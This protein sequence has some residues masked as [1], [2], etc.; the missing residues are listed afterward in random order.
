MI[1]NPKEYCPQDV[2]LIFGMRQ[3]IQ[4]M[5]PLLKVQLQQNKKLDKMFWLLL[6]QNQEVKNQIMSYKDFYEKS[7][8][9]NVLD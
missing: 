3:R 7:R 4:K 8:K 1:A 2:A 5:K 9:S 6:E